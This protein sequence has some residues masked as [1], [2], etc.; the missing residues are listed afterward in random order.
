[1]E[2]GWRATDLSLTMIGK[3][4]GGEDEEGETSCAGCQVVNAENA[5]EL[6][7]NRCQ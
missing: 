5:V 2:R 4:R 3:E 6:S 1:M 7:R